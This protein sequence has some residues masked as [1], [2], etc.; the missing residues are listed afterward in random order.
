MNTLILD[1]NQVVNSLEASG[2]NR[3]QAE[4]ITTT[5][6]KLDLSNL[7]T[8]HEIKELRHELELTE[9]RLETSIANIKVDMQKFIFTALFA[10]AGL[11]V[12]LVKLIP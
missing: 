1:S 11:I 10:Q 9:S 5:L 7:A 6:N 12:A 2:F 4:G 3:K 8:K